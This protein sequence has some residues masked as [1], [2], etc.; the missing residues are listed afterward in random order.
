MRITYF[1]HT[2]TTDNEAGLAT[3][4]IQGELS[5]NG[6]EQARSLKVMLQDRTF[7]AVFTSD[8]RRAVKSTELFF[9]SRFPVFIDWRLRECNYGAFDG[10]LAMD[11]KKGH[12]AEFISTPYEGGESYKDVEQRTKSFLNSLRLLSYDHIAIVAH[13]APQLALDV[14]LKERS[15]EQAIAEDWRNTR[16]WQPGW[17]YQLLEKF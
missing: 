17:E 1:V 9:D 7:D 2:T 6:L 11:F 12:E 8:L 10:K 13:Q 14:L 15:W 4:W 16:N 3:G 5:E